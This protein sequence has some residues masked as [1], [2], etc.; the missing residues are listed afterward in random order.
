MPVRLSD[1]ISLSTIALIVCASCTARADHT[2]NDYWLFLL[3]PLFA[4][5][6]AIWFKA[7][8]RSRDIFVMVFVASAGYAV[9]FFV[10]KVRCLS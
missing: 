6:L 8:W 10:E 1:G 4:Y 7:D 9:N 5:S 3:V 2:A